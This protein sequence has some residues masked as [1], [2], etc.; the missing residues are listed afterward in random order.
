MK[1]LW[2]ALKT[3]NTKVNEFLLSCGVETSRWAVWTDNMVSYVQSYKE[4]PHW[5]KP[6]KLAFDLFDMVT[7]NGC[8]FLGMLICA[9]LVF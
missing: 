3:L 5:K 1:T 2:N 4:V 9:C 6:I 8:A 7:Y